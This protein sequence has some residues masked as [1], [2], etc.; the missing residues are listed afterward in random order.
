MI[1]SHADLW[2]C[3]QLEASYAE[4]EKQKA[5]RK[6]VTKRLTQKELEC[7]SLHSKT[8]DLQ[9]DDSARAATE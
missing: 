4:L 5:E 7:L 3:T 6:E 2:L 9:Q 8:L 1:G